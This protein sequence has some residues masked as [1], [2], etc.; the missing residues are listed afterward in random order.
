MSIYYG[1]ATYTIHGS[2][3]EQYCGGMDVGELS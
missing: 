3:T 1:K 2:W